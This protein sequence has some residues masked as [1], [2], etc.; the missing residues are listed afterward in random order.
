MENI[1]TIRKKK[2]LKQEVIAEA[3]GIKQSA[4]SN[5]IR[6]ESD[7][8]WSRLLQISNIFEMD[9]IDVITYPV[10]YVP[11]VEECQ[12][13]KEKDKI[14]ENLNDLIEVLKKKNK[15]GAM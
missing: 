9:V 1:E 12:R 8:P 10:K 13:C 11:A 4:Y 6:R 15:L 5:Y 2:G 3:L 7:I 14:I